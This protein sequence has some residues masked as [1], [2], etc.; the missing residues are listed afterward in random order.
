MLPGTEYVVPAARADG[1]SLATWPGTAGILPGTARAARF[2]EGGWFFS[3]IK[4]VRDVQAEAGP[5]SPIQIRRCS[6]DYTVVLEQQGVV[7]AGRLARRIVEARAEVMVDRFA[8]LGRKVPMELLVGLV[9]DFVYLKRTS[10]SIRNA[11]AS[12][13]RLVGTLKTYAHSDQ[14]SVVDVDLTEGLETTLTI[15]H[16]AMRC[17]ININRK[18]DVALP[19]V[20][21]YADE[22]NQVWTNLIQ[23]SIQAMQGEGTI[24]IET[25]CEGGHVGVR[26]CDSGPGIAEEVLPRV[27][28]PFFTTKPRGEGTGLGLSIVQRIVQKHGGRIDVES[29]AGRTVFKV[30]L[31]LLGP[32][33]EEGVEDAE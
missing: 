16:N 30:T 5:L 17:G 8:T 22:L 12:I 11:I 15:L 13:V 31:P 1:S 19:R 25:F 20:P 21:V 32:P 24:D 26:I 18:Y 28:E 6:R 7:D 2:E 29:E 4:H 27:F 10:M 23:N 3:G 9:E 33:T 14:V